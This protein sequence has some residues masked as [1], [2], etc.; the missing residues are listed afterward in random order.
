LEGLIGF[1]VNLLVLRTDLSGSPSVRQVLER[2]KETVL[3]AYM[4]QEVPFELVV[5]RLDPRHPRDRMPLVQ[6]L[7][8]MQ[9]LPGGQEA[10]VEGLRMRGVNVE[11][12]TAKFDLALFVQEEGQGMRAGVSYSTALFEDRSI[13]RLMSRYERVLQQLVAFPDQSVDTL[14]IAPVAEKARRGKQ[15]EISRSRLKSAKGEEFDL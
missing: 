11:G 9:N 4:H 13:Q 10:E 7:F 6:V 2:V 15:Q 5:E 8:V 1:F 12:G 14:E 3:G